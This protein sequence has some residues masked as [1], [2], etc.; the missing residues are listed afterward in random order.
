MSDG[1]GQGQ[2]SVIVSALHDQ[3][4]DRRQQVMVRPSGTVAGAPVPS[5]LAADSLQFACSGA[6]RTDTAGQ[7]DPVVMATLPVNRLL[8][9]V[10][11][12]MVPSAG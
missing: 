11:R 1:R 7:I 8:T 2:P 9:I 12:Q 3:N 5:L 10:P 6:A 4:T